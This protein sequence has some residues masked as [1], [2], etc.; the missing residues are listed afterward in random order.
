MKFK[1]LRNFRLLR[2]V[3]DFNIISQNLEK[4]AQFRGTNL[5]ILFF[6]ILIASLGLNLNSTA[7]V[8]GAMLISPLMGP[9]VGV[10]VA[11]E[12]N[13]LALLRRASANYFF[14]AAIGLTAST[15]YF[16]VTPIN[17]AHSEI[18]SRTSPTVYDALI[19]LFGGFAGIIAISSKL[20][21]NVI[22]GVAI[23]TA[24]MPPICTAGYGLATWQLNYF[25]GA[26]Y[27]YIINSVFIATATIITVY[28]L[29][30]PKKEY[31]DAGEKKRT[32]R[33][34]WAIVIITLTPS[35]Y[36]AYDIVQEGRFTK[37]ATGFV[38]TEAIFPND[39]LL[40]REINA[41]KKLITLTYGGKQITDSEIIVLKGKLKNYGL[42]NASIKI[43]QGFSFLT[44]ENTKQ[45]NQLGLALNQSEEKSSV[46]K[47]RLDSINNQQLLSTQI[48][49]EMDVQYP[50]LKGAIIQP[51]VVQGDTS[52]NKLIQYLALL[53][54]SKEL[55]RSEKTKLE[56]WLK[57]RLNNDSARIVYSDGKLN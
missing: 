49:R 56:K 10:G 44:D 52:K 26:I 53:Y 8:I 9:I 13:D 51:V 1:L 34:I 17:E 46:L 55:K 3:E 18:L 12:I 38:D 14:A 4:E 50:G 30:F 33:I 16:L 20:K 32:N 36:L 43:K 37:K 2:D 21:G 31:A 6:A 5:W 24:L 45:V 47:A 7:V 28:L 29:K 35:I 15:L 41:D 39:Y 40:R 19:A 23:A 11:V 42:Q 54:F 25:L 57:V 27:L 22:P 48:Y